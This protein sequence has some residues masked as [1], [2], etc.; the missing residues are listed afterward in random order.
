MKTD[1]YQLENPT[2]LIAENMDNMQYEKPTKMTELVKEYLFEFC[3]EMGISE[4]ELSDKILIYSNQVD[5]IF[6]VSLDNPENILFGVSSIENGY[7]I[8]GEYFENTEKFPKT[9]AL[10]STING[11]IA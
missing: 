8:I 4:K 3:S 2:S 1:E 5:S 10:I 9:T 6:V 11:G 7:D